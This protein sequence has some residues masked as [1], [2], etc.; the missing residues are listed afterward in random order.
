MSEYIKKCATL[1]NLLLTILLILNIVVL[2]PFYN[3][4]DNVRENISRVQSRIDTLEEIIIQY[5]INNAVMLNRL[6]TIDNNLQK[7]QELLE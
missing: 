1:P 6:N 7:I 5:R 2:S 4:L 3:S